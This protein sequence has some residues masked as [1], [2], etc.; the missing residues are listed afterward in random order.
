MNSTMKKTGL[1]TAMLSAAILGASCAEIEGEGEEIE[2]AQGALTQ[3]TISGKITMSNGTPVSG[4]PVRLNGLSQATKITTST[5]AY[6]FTGIASGSYSVRP[7]K[8]GCSFSPDVVNLNNQTTNVTTNFTAS[9]TL[10]TTS[11]TARALVLMDSRL[12]AQLGSTFDTWKTLVEARRGFALDV[13]KDQQYDAMTFAA[14]KNVIVSAR[15]A[16]P[17]L[18]GVLMVGNIKL[19]S[20][21][22]VRADIPGTRLLP[23]YYEDLD[24][25]FT[26]IYADGE[27]DPICQEGFLPGTKCVVSPRADN[28]T[29]PVTVIKHDFDDTNFGPN[30]DPEIWASFMPVGVS[31]SANSYTDFG[32]QLKP[33]F[34]KLTRFY[35]HELRS[36]GRYY[37]I[38]NGPGERFDEAWNAFGKS[39][40]DFYGKSGPN[41]ETGNAC[42]VGSNNICYVRWP[43]DSYASSATFLSAY[44]ATPWVGEGW[45]QPSIFSSHMNANL[46]DVAHV[47]TH[48]SE[49]EA[50]LSTAQARALT[51]GG[52][53]TVLDGCGVAGF[54]QPG[55]PTQSGVDTTAQVSDNVLLAY[56]YGSSKALAAFGAPFWRGEYIEAPVLY[57]TLKVNGTPTASYLGAANLVRMK[58]IY[59]NT[60]GDKYALK[61]MQNEIMV[62]DPFIDLKP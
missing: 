20:F 40:I 16:N 32:N 50:L 34:Q 62:G 23:R 6:A 61:S 15:T 27:I 29:G 25:P 7:E 59:S 9:G 44:A 1:M 14:I 39:N 13:R 28:S 26:K 53:I 18:Q 42:L 54:K 17:A 58:R 43:L 46:Y 21:Y 10:C 60:G 49:F 48:G 31:G 19:P 36:N 22:K 51:N 41:G 24:A 30:S 12:Y 35:N 37:F 33:Y 4:V 2:V 11:G 8:T 38:S 47:V 45:Q 5:G 56:L 57:N 52:L 55:A 3:I